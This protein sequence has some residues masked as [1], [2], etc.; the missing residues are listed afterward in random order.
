VKR[1]LLI[2]LALLILGSTTALGWLLNSENGLRFVY[3]QLQP[4]LPGELHIEQ[5]SGSLMDGIELHDVKYS[6]TGLGLTIDRLAL[7]WNPR[8]LLGYRVEISSLDI[9]QLSLNI[10]SSQSDASTAGTEL[11]LP[12]FQLP[13]ELELQRVMIAHIRLHQDDALYQLQQVSLQLEGQDSNFQIEQLDLQIIELSI[14]ENEPIDIDASLVGSIQATADYQH[15]LRIDWK[16]RL[17]TGLAIDTSSRLDGNLQATG[18]TQ[19][20]SEPLEARLDLD[21][22]TPLEDLRWQ[23]Q[24]QVDNF[25]TGMLDAGLP[26]LRGTAAVSAG[27]DLQSARVNG[28]IE[29]DSTELGKIDSQFELRSLEPA[30]LFDGLLVESIKLALLDG[31][32]TGRGKLN[33][34]PALSWESEVKAS[35]INPASLLPEWPGSL[36]IKLQSEGR[37]DDGNLSAR[38]QVTESSG[39]LRGYPL[40]LEGIA[41]WSDDG[42]EIDS[43]NLQSGNTRVLAAGKVGDL[44]ELQWS[45]A[46][47]D[48]GELY[49]GAQGQL[50]AEGRLG[51]RVDAPAIEARFVGNRLVLD[52]YKLSNV[53]GEAAVNLNDWQQLDISFVAQ[54][55]ELEGQHLES[56]SVA[57]AKG[58]IDAGLSSAGLK[59][60][61]SLDG[62][63][64]GQSWQGK[65]L[66]AEIQSTEY[67]SWRLQ[68]SVTLALSEANITSETIC[69]ASPEQGEL[70]SSVVGNNQGK[71]WDWDVDIKL[72]KLPLQLLR[73]WTPDG[74]QLDGSADATAELRY[75]AAGVLLGKLDLGLPAATASYPLQPESPERFDYREGRLQLALESDGIRSQVALVLENGDQL[76]GSVEMPGA[77][78]LEFDNE[79][80]QIRGSA[81]LSVGNWAMLDARIPQVSNLRGKLE[82]ALNASGSLAQPRFV[83]NARLG[84]GGFFLEAQKSEV[85][86]IEFNASSDGSE[87]L[88]FDGKAV[89]ARGQISLTGKTVLQQEAGWPGSV[90]LTVKGAEVSQ[91]LEPWLA[92]PL[93]A[94]GLLDASA[95]LEFRAPDHLLGKIEVTLPRGS[96]NYPLLEQEKES[97]EYHQGF[98]H[99]SLEPDGIS[100]SSGIQIGPASKVEAKARLAGA[101]LLTL[102]PEQQPMEAKARV[103][104]EELDLVEFLVPDIDQ[105]KGQLLIDVSAGGKLAKPLIDARAQIPEGSF[106]VPRL[107]LEISDIELQGKSSEDLQRFEFVLTADSGEG[108]L[109]I[110]GN[111]HLDPVNGWP[112][113]IDV[114]GSDF[115][116]SRIPEAL[117]TISPDLQIAIEKRS[118]SIT[119]DLLIP[120]A[121]L[122]PRDLSTA[123]RVSNDTVIIGGEQEPAERW[124]VTT[125]VNLALGDRVTFFGF[126][127]EG[128]LGGQLLV[129]DIPGQLSVGTGEITIIEGRYRAYGQRLDINNGR[130]LFTGSPLDNPG[131]DMRAIREVNEVT[132]GLRV[133]GRLQRPQLE[134]FS[135]PSMGE[136]DM[137]SYLLFGRPLDGASGTE[138]EMMARAALALGLAGGDGL[139]RQLGDRFGFDEM[140]VESDSRGEQ[141]SLVVG[142]YLAPKLYVSYGVGLVESVNKVNLRYELTDRWKLEAESGIHQGADLLY[143]IE[144]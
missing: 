112:T 40:A 74:L 44:L 118:I 89:F 55:I 76:K 23:A 120:L 39:S 122:Q 73:R 42:I 29:A 91:L 57:A 51:G 126:G 33:W 3:R 61:I 100:A 68:D 109:S 28:R 90:N 123:A 108:E 72:A 88:Q 30:Q 8:A 130:V 140:R 87:S 117:V 35:R 53:E 85:T 115:E 2:I 65:L 93:S 34:T 94:D 36:N 110:R 20:F 59:A 79:N 10:D 6:D 119:G 69:L 107:G 4:A 96:L 137:L 25:D 5:I 41:Y 27:G 106:R 58:R 135:N 7:Q 60:Q 81:N 105:V 116:V 16:T 14:G 104:F 37:F 19:Q 70:C 86:E 138:G 77:R 102:D 49:P 84:N 131:L 17:P 111:S 13:V 144:R 143:S 132:V 22:E 136:T 141:A 134:L 103:K 142:R 24:L 67:S 78:I 127:F 9:G 56:V 26:L 121:K 66:S 92:P 75:S 129:E 43:A 12:Q 99:L 98:A 113:R 31:E 83:G 97:W 54:D 52:D 1:A 46:S 64:L 71:G 133:L 63:F 62:E 95:E 47:G 21:L 82:I 11:T 50:Q 101:R 15:A 38:L 124:L 80:Q 125:R 139:A 32:I 18:L 45:V 128:R 114:R 48:L